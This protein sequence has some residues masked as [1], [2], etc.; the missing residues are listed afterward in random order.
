MRRALAASY[1]GAE[2]LSLSRGASVPRPRG[3]E[4]LIRV[5]ASSIN[6]IDAWMMRGYGKRLFPLLGVEPPFTPGRDVVG[7]IVEVGPLAWN[8]AVGEMVAAATHPTAEGGHADFTVCAE[9]AVARLPA[10]V[11]PVLA[12]A[13]PFASLT[14]WKA[15]NGHA[16]VRRGQSVLVH[17]ATGSVGGFA[18]QY[19]KHLGCRV[20][21]TCRP[22][23][24]QL[25]RVHA[26]GA[27]VVL[28]LPEFLERA[29]SGAGSDSHG[30]DNAELAWYVAVSRSLAESANWSQNLR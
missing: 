27:D 23:A 19:L 29:T 21:A 28:S 16:A 5:T 24:D 25:E 9:S 6:P 22:E 20:V 12:A 18:V 7:E 14:A 2:V 26:L 3:N 4:L 30:G 10:T 13:L 11:D 17:G 8:Y 1:G 15:L